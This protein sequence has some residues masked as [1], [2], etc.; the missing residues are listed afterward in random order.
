MDPKLTYLI[1]SHSWLIQ[2]G[3]HTEK[4]VLIQFVPYGEGERLRES[5]VT[6]D[7]DDSLPECIPPRV[8][9]VNIESQR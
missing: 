1:E 4:Q 5:Q 9:T 7:I 3:I 2:Q 6:Q 8:H